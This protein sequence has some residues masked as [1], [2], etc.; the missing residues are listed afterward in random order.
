ML[1][2]R[3]DFWHV[4]MAVDDLDAAM[5]RYSQAFGIEWGRV[6]EFT[7]GG[8][9]LSPEVTMEMPVISPVHGDG[10]SMEGLRQ[11]CGVNVGMPGLEGLPVGG[12]E[13]SCAEKFSPAYTIWGAP[14]GREYMHHVAYW[15]DDVQDESR[16]LLERGFVVELAN[17]PGVAGPG[18]AYVVSPEGLRIEL[19]DRA[20]RAA[21]G[22]FY[23]GADLDFA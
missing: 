5:A 12:I 19:V 9:V 23:N 20:T 17:R 10:A 6:L 18:F 15:V 21:V 8:L 22:P 4:S 7:S 3:W 16:R 2:D 11:V 1:T 13:L 14:D